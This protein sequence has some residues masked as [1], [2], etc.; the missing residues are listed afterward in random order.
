MLHDGETAKAFKSVQT[1][2]TVH[3]RTGI[4]PTSPNE[5]TLSTRNPLTCLPSG[6]FCAPQ[7]FYCTLSLS[8]R[9]PE[10]S[11]RRNHFSYIDLSSVRNLTECI[12]QSPSFVDY[13][14]LVVGIIALHPAAL[15]KLAKSAEPRLYAGC[16][17]GTSTTWQKCCGSMGQQAGELE[18]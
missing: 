16:C 15:S 8:S 6:N 11:I 1:S 9:S 10:S 4:K 13:R 12:H 7:I 14:T 5:Q 17:G 3:S 2:N 18:C